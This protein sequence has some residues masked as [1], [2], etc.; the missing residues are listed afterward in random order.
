M[1]QVYTGCGKGKTT[2]ALGAALRAAGAGLRIYIC[3]FMKGKYYCELATLKKLK[4]I[5]VEQFGTTCFVGRQPTRKDVEL[6][7]LGLES[8]IKAIRSKRYDMIILDEINVAVKLGLLQPEDVV[9]IL[10]KYPKKKELI[11]TGRYAHPKIIKMADLVSEIKE[12][13]HY[14]KKGVKAR[15][16]IEF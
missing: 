16:G 2:A 14:Y 9:T 10:N 6:A 11:L 3:Q 15:K 12:V 4:K 5:K 7:K 1:I 13:K 8:A